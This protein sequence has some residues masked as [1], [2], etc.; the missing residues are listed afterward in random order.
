MS[1]TIKRRDFLK[2]SSR[3]AALAGLGGCGILL[4]GCRKRQEFDLVISGGTVIDGT[5]GD[6][7]M[8][9]VGIVGDSIVQVGDI[10]V[11]WGKKVLDARGLTICPGFI[12]THDHSDVNLLYNPKAE[13]HIRQGITTVISGNCGSSPFPVADEIFEE[14]QAALKEA[15]DI[16][17]TWRDIKGFLA[18]MQ[19]TGV[20]LNYATYVGQGTIR[21]AAMGFNDRPPKPDELERMK[22]LVKE[23]MESGALGLSTGLE[24]APG[25]FAQPDEV[26][27]LCRVAVEYGG[28]Y[29]THMRDEGD[30]LLEA[31]D[32]AIGVARRTGAGLQISHFK[33]AYSRNWHKIDDALARIDQAVEEG[34][35]VFCD[36]YPYIAGSTGF[37]SFNFPLWALQGTTE[38]FLARLKD[39]TLESRLRTYVSERE[40]KLG[41]WDKVVI[42]SVATDKNQHFEGK[43]VL[44]GMQETGKDAFEF[45]RD[46]VIEEN[47]RMSQIIFMM[48]EDNLKR[49]LAHPRVGVGCDGSA[50]APYGELGKG[51]P[52]PRSYGT[53]PRVLGKYIREEKI[54]P[55]TEMIKKMTSVPAAKFGFTGRGILQNGKLA[56]IVI[57]DQ[58]RVA[59]RATWKEPHQYPV[60]IEHVIVN[61]QVVIENS[62]HT[63]QLPGRILRPTPSSS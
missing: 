26:A 32:E 27:E 13:S 44:E 6:P 25:S 61:G 11:S 40:E 41:S 42:A 10:Q 28:L 52:H 31:L 45:M 19:E 14:S 2:H 51:K 29:A 57:F 3:A 36:R 47:N 4:K 37:S 38:E 49:I 16:E 18:R 63:G 48:N 7:R 50:M 9:D 34:I 56:D 1:K 46:L 20:A 17:L 33:I 5:G 55:L 24:Y 43:S 54:L 58:E 8:A 12:D 15:Y 22:T 21:G 30:Q 53:F 35:D 59:D 62:E 39:P 23:S 60:G